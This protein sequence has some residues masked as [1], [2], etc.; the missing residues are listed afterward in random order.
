MHKLIVESATYRQSSNIRKDLESQDPDNK[1]LARQIASS[2]SGGA[3]PGC[4]AWRPADLL[5]PAIGG[6][7][8]PAP[9]A[10]RRSGPELRSSEGE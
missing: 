7:E 3:G 6:Q 2:S 1:L 5:N 4:D 9:G 10:C 8:Y